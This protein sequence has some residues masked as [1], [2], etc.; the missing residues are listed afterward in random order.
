MS[1]HSVKAAACALAAALLGGLWGCASEPPGG[2]DDADAFNLA[3]FNV[4][5][6]T[7]ADTGDRAW[8]A[9]LPRIVQVV[10]DRGFDVFGVQ[11]ARKVQRDELL[12]AL[13]GWALVGENATGGPHGEGDYILFAT[14]RFACVKTDTFWLSETPRTPGS[15]SWNSKCTR[16]CT[17]AVLRDL[18]TG[19]TLRYYNTHLDHRS[20]PA[21]VEGMKVILSEIGACP[22]GDAVVLTGDLNSPQLADVLP[23]DAPLKDSFF[24]SETPREGPANTLHCYRDKAYSRIDYVLVSD[25]LRVLRHVTCDDRPGGKFPSDHDA[26]LV[27]LKFRQ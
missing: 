14:N 10:R 3:T 9:R 12:A 2:R 4:R 19:R 5:C 18:R 1:S 8:A 13:P 6:L 7:A 11:E 21:R 16:V 22:P 25:G 27:R 23:A 17:L 24:L 15:R 26:V 20:K